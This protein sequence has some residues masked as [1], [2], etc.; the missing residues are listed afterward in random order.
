M[1]IGMPGRRRE[2]D[3][4]VLW[5]SCPDRHRDREADRA[6]RSWPWCG[7][8]QVLG[9]ALRLLKT[10]E[11]RQLDIVRGRPSFT[12]ALGHAHFGR[13]HVVVN[14]AGCGVFGTVEKLGEDA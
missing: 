7:R 9:L 14:N 6:G 11:L 4:G 3:R 5:G 1:R 13:L 2:C 10:G 12:V 8:A